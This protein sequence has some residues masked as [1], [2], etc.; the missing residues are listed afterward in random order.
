MAIRVQKKHYRESL[1]ENNSK[2]QRIRRSKGRKA[3]SYTNH[4]RETRR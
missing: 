1:V 2:K 4:R 3:H